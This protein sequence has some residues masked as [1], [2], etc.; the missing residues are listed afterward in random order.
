M[1]KVW[2]ERFRVFTPEGVCLSAVLADPVSRMWAL[3]I[4][5]LCIGLILLVVTLLTVFLLPYEL[6]IGLWSLLTFVVLWGYFF[7]F[8]W[9]NEGCTP[10]KRII[11]LQVVSLSL[12]PI[13]MRQAAWRNVLRYV[14]FMPSL[15]GLGLVCILLSPHHQRLGDWLSGTLVIS[16]KA[17]KLLMPK[18]VSGEAIP[19]PYPLNASEQRLL[20]QFAAYAVQV[21]PQRSAEMSAPFASVWPELNEAERVARLIGYGRWYYQAG[22]ATGMPTKDLSE[23][24]DENQA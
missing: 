8:E 24:V 3:V 19:S 15:F 11:G 1:N 22:V 23:S 21:S 6:Q 13:S 7:C 20:V 2:D 12:S 9:L 14:D 10:G 17:P 16:S 4:D 5:G 18:V